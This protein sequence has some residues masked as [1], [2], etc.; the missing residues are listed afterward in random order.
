M[1]IDTTGEWWVG[2]GEDDID[3]YLELL[4]ADVHPISEVVH[5]TCGCGSR[6]FTVSADA[7]EGCV[8]RACSSCTKEH[9]VCDSGEYVEDSDLEGVVCQCGDERFELAVSFSRRDDGSIRWLAVGVRCVACGVLGSPAD[10][11]IDYSPSEHLTA[12]V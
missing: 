2:T 12:Q 4:M 9:P 7:D 11:K 8:I 3:T 1:A 6:V 5:A 10:C